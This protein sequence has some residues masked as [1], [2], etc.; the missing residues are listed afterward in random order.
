MAASS[1]PAGRGQAPAHAASRPIPPI[2]AATRA[3]AQAADAILTRDNWAHGSSA[4][5]IENQRQAD[6]QYFLQ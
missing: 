3:C 4:V 2:S 1:K 6:S 5:T